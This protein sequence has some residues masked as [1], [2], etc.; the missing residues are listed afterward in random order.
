M[1]NIQLYAIL[2]FLTVRG[3]TSTSRTV[4]LFYDRAHNIAV[5]IHN[6]RRRKHLRHR[7]PNDPSGPDHLTSVASY[8]QQ[9][10]HGVDR[11]VNGHAQNIR[12]IPRIIPQKR[13]L[14]DGYH[15]LV[16]HSEFYVE[17]E[18]EEAGEVE[19]DVY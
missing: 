19:D 3:V 17:H 13:R 16:A 18:V 11:R 12:Q 9:V 7:V 6:R 15:V 2:C 5:N 4:T 10:Y 8:P 14:V 1:R